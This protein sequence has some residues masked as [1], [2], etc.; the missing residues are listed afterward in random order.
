MFE[1]VRG[2]WMVN[3]SPSTYRLLEEK[4]TSDKTWTGNFEAVKEKLKKKKSE[5][6][7]TVEVGNLEFSFEN[8]IYSI[9]IIKVKP[10]EM[11]NGGKGS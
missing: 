10:Q 4:S 3:C 6:W 8:I 11:G 9:V 1:K 2:E 7:A 5:I